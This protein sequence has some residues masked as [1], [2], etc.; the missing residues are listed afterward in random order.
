MMTTSSLLPLYTIT[1]PPTYF[2]LPEHLCVIDI[3]DKMRRIHLLHRLPT[4]STVLLLLLLLVVIV[5]N[6]L[7]GAME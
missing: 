2:T 7:D 5:I 3:W 4:T 6:P 1:H